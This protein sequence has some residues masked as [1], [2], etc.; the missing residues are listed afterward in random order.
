VLRFLQETLANASR[1]AEGR[2]IE[3]DLACAEGELRLST[4]D[5]GPGLR[6]APR[7]GAMG[8]AGLRDRVESLGG[9]FRAATREGGGA[10]VALTL[11]TGG[12][13]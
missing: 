3:V 2:G 7:E 4:R 10:E 5:R 12:P 6:G 1:H 13:A 11:E 9:T 8:L